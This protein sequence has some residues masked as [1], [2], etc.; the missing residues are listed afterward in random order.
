M[1]V[2]KI[3][4]MVRFPKAK[5]TTQK[6]LQKF[7]PYGSDFNIPE[8]KELQNLRLPSG[9]VKASRTALRIEHEGRIL[10]TPLKTNYGSVL[11][12]LKDPVRKGRVVLLRKSGETNDPFGR[13]LL[14]SLWNG[15]EQYIGG[16][17]MVRHPTEQNCGWIKHL[18]IYGDVRRKPSSITAGE[19]IELSKRRNNPKHRKLALENALEEHRKREKIVGFE[20][21]EELFKKEWTKHNLGPGK[22]D[23][24]EWKYYDWAYRDKD[25]KIKRYDYRSKKLSGA[26]YDLSVNAAKKA[27]LRFL[28][29]ALTPS[30]T[31]KYFDRYGWVPT[32]KFSGNYRIYRLNLQAEGG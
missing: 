14:T 3:G 23:I 13:Y 17:Y 19:A 26:I 31:E 8:K 2:E 21:N 25:A 30:T 15:H 12:A 6:H 4:R 18:E 28:E 29:G 24:M 11:L 5:E 16:M 9:A 32:K 7:R 1:N 10:E 27:G 22:I 20:P